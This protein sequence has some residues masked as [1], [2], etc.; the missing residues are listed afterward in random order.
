MKFWLSSV[1]VALALCN[2][3]MVRADEITLV[4]PGGM[5]C[6]L[7]KLTPGFEAKT[8]HKI[9]ATVGS[10]G[11]TH[12]QVVKGDLF[13]VPVVQPPYDDVIK[14]GNVVANTETWF[15][16]VPMVVVVKKGSPKPDIST[17]DAVKKLL[18][19]AK[20]LSYPD[21]RG[22]RGGAAG[23]SFD[24][25]QKQLGIFDQVQA[26]VKRTEGLSLMKAVTTGNIDFAVT[27][28]S[29]V[30]DPDVDIVGQLPKA[31]STPT[32]LVGFV[33]TRAKSPEAAKALL[34]HFSGP[35]AAAAYG[36]CG[37]QAGHP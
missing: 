21:G 4:A 35:E 36:A 18:L 26:K 24:A 17:P 13:D 27:F 20:Y 29:E 37:M 28:A 22:G 2:A 7:D 33:H 23:V 8:G 25:T 14:S 11:A 32:G 15:G 9:K 12:M 31:I 6:A 19:G 10:G 30:N 1:V 16:S 5:R 34:T 3:Q